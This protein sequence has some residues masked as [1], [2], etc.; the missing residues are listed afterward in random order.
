MENKRL[1][2]D[3]S[4]LMDDSRF[5][6]NNIDNYNIIISDIVLSELDNLKRNKDVLKA[7]RA[8]KAIQSIYSNIK[9]L[10]FDIS[11][12][13][14]L[15]DFNNNDDRILHIANKNGA[16]VITNDVCMYIKAKSLNIDVLR[17]ENKIEYR[18]Y[19]E[20]VLS[21]SELS[22]LY[23]N[24]DKNIYDN[25][26]NE[27]LIVK[28]ETTGVV[29]DILRWTEDGYVRIQEKSIKGSTLGNIYAKDEIQKCAFDSIFSNDITILYGRSGSGKTTIPLFYAIS[30]LEKHKISKLYIIYS[31]TPLRNQETLGFEKGDHT[32]KVMNYGAIGNILSTKFGKESDV[33]DLISKGLIEIIPTAN[34]RGVEFEE[35]SMVM[36]TEAQNL[37]TYTLKTIIQRC[38][39]GCKQ[40]YEGDILEQT[41]IDLFENGMERIIEKLRGTSRFGCVKLNRNYRDEIGQLIDDL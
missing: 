2:I 28:D 24:L 10:E 5:I 18:G 13:Y 26:V 25:F 9:N 38:K 14:G 33:I 37:D 35:K 17:I 16:T 40:V 31:F 27:Y 3:T 36:C 20:I 32:E 15:I 29:V 12:G 6:D 4:V 1:L 11:N 41:D 8:K 23:S 34:I 19:K 39:R 7:K 30:Q 22:F 21:E